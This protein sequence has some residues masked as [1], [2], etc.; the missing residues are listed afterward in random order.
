[1]MHRLDLDEG[2]WEVLK[3][4][5]GFHD[6]EDL[7]KIVDTDHPE[8]LGNVLDSLRKKFK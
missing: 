6:V 4:V 1:M 8:H 3:S 2:E 7:E 5:V